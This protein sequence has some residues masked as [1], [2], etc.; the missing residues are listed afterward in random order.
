MTS[1]GVIELDGA[2]G[3][4]G[5][6]ILRT[7]L[8][9]SMVTGRACRIEN[10]RAGR[11]KPGLLRQHLTAVQAAARVSG[12]Q[13]EGAAIGAAT[14]TFAPG[15]VTSGEYHFAIGTAGSTTLVLQTLL[16]ALIT[17]PAPS[18]IT[19]EGGTHNTHAP[20]VHFLARAFLPLLERMGPRVEL[21]LERHGFYPA[22][23]GRIVASITPCKALRPLTL[24]E[25][26]EI[27]QRRAIATVAG[28]PG[29]IAKRE[30]AAFAQ[31]LNWPDD[32]LRIER[33]PDRVGPGN[34]LSVEVGDGV[35]TEVFTGFGQKG[36]SAEKVGGDTAEEVCAYLAGGAPV[37][38]YLAD[39]LMVPMA[40]AGG[41]ALRTGPLT[42]HASTNAAVIR[43]F[44]SADLRCESEGRLTT[45][46]AG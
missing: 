33:L 30:L 10:I 31:R 8:G 4:G 7:A 41:G 34:V 45:V 18:T 27:T 44:L 24:L 17:A 22:G 23:G 19:I 6:Q 35:V 42:S 5:G 29:A 13:V 9:L 39:Q 32:A 26:G 11:A 28:L 36:V 37:G 40:L 3:E 16:P 15:P 1:A 25:R 38:P 46:T 12:A 20:S 21:R 43:R 14:L 2:L